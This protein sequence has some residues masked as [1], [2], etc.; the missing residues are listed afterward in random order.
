MASSS[1]V[2]PKVE[3]GDDMP[4]LEDV[5]P[6]QLEY[7]QAISAIGAGLV[8][9]PI[10]GEVE[11]TDIIRYI[12]TH[13]D[14][15]NVQR[16]FELSGK[17][18]ARQ[19]DKRQQVLESFDPSKLGVQPGTTWLIALEYSGLT[20]DERIDDNW[21][22]KKPGE[23][24]KSKD[25][26][27]EPQQTF[28]LFCYIREGPGT[29]GGDN[30]RH[31]ED[32]EKLLLKTIS[33]E[34]ERDSEA[35]TLIAVCWANCSAAN[36]LEVEGEERDL[37]SA[38]ANA[39]KAILADPGYAKGYVRLSR[40]YELS[41]NASAAQDAL[42]R[43]L[44]LKEVEN[45]TGLADHLISLQTSG[46]GLPASKDEFESWIKYVLEEDQESAER[47]RGLGGAWKKRCDE[48]LKKLGASCRR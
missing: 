33:E 48:H 47:M 22:P 41:G 39:E 12:S 46:K 11:F 38:K 14:D 17:R 45:H 44:R 10:T 35:R 30:S 8:P 36:M 6:E 40:A 28:Q 2:L 23:K 18:N 25:P 15:P 9:D 7:Q 26:K 32:L 21:V 34:P 3:S 13:V 4:D 19:K 1:S 43:G 29:D 5:D 37:E 16:F 31:I 27:E 42:L 24:E 20:T